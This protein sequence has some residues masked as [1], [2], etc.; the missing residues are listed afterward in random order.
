M[1]RFLILLLLGLAVYLHFGG[2]LLWSQQA[3]SASDAAKTDSGKAVGGPAETKPAAATLNG[4]KSELV[5]PA[6]ASPSIG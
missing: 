2:G 5:A 3:K 4:A 1:K 6:V